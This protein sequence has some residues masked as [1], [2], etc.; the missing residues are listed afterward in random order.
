MTAPDKHYVLSLC[1][2]H[3]IQLI[4]HYL[5]HAIMSARRSHKSRSSPGATAAAAAA[6][7][8]PS[9]LTKKFPSMRHDLAGELSWRKQRDFLP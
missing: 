5:D 1:A 3:I 8:Q 6:V 9:T 7:S 4:E 2:L